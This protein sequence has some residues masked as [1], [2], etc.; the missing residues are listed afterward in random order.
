MLGG[1]LHQRVSDAEKGLFL[2]YWPRI[3][4]GDMPPAIPQPAGGSFHLKQEFFELK[5][6]VRMRGLSF[7]EFLAL[8][9]K[10]PLPFKNIT[11]L[12]TLILCLSHPD[13]SGM[14]VMVGGKYGKKYEISMRPVE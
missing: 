10:E 13:Y 4:A 1:T 6:P 5:E 14:I 8:D 2:E 7:D 12:L 9:D 11:E 3:V